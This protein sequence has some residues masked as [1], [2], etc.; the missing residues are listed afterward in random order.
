MR[1]NSSVIVRA[2]REQVWE[3]IT[4]PAAY[5]DFMSGVTRWDIEGEVGDPDRT[6]VIELGSR[7][8]MLMRVGSAEVGGLIEMVECSGQKDLA[9]SAVTGVDQ[10]GRWRLRDVGENLTR[11]ELRFS[12]GVAG[13][14]I[15]G[16]L[17]ERVAAP[18]VRSRLRS[19]V[20]E[21][22][23]VV[24][25]DWRREQANRRREATAA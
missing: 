6:D 3:T 10:R 18:I 20:Q 4:D 7:I 25:R 5:L 17:A 16:M 22:K 11:V 13:A 14:G 19:S 23:K 12:Y 1:V 21:L 8:R 9:W 15:R 24:E 2:P